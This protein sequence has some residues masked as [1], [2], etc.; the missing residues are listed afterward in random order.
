MPSPSVIPKSHNH[1]ASMPQI[2][3]NQLPSDSFAGLRN[4]FKTIHTSINI[5]T[6]TSTSTPPSPKPTKFDVRKTRY[7]RLPHKPLALVVSPLREDPCPPRSAFRI[8]C[9][10]YTAGVN[11]AKILRLAIGWALE[12]QQQHQQLNARRSS[13]AESG[14]ANNEVWSGVDGLCGLGGRVGG[15][16]TIGKCRRGTMVI[17]VWVKLGVEV[18]VSFPWCRSTMDETCRDALDELLPQQRLLR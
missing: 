4:P 1:T 11:R 15:M 3:N 9:F 14:G 8:H 12:N 16:R 18:E 2:F 5:S 13:N 7:S 17:G 10:K 6:S